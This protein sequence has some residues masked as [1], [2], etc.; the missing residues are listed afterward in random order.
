M[1]LRYPL[2]TAIDKFVTLRAKDAK[3]GAGRSNITLYAPQTFTVTDGAGYGNFDLGVLGTVGSGAID[4]MMSGESEG[5][6]AAMTSQLQGATGGD[7]Y[8]FMKALSRAGLGNGTT[9]RL[10]DIYG[11]NN[12]VAANPNTVLQF[13]NTEIR[14]FNLEFRMIAQSSPESQQ[15]KSIITSMRRSLYPEGTNLILNYP[16]VWDVEFITGS[17]RYVPRFADCYLTNMSTTYN[18]SG[19]MWHDDGAPTD[20]TVQLQF[21]EFKALK[22]EDIDA[23]DAGAKVTIR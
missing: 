1:S 2:S 4:K 6:A 20:V 21:R 11:Y 18:S 17:E 16:D 10:T 19:N 13:T 15:I 23:L 9:D 22:R 12:K 14:G 7:K 5:Q 3:T 8:L